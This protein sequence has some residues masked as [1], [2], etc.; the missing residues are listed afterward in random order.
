MTPYR[1]IAVRDMRNKSQR[2][3]TQALPLPPTPEPD[4]GRHLEGSNLRSMALTAL[5]N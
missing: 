1:S 3:L 2:S 4:N 5:L